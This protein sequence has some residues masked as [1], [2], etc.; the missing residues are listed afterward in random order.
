MMRCTIVIFGVHFTHEI[1]SFNCVSDVDMPVL[2][3]YLKFTR[4]FISLLGFIA[5]YVI[6]FKCKKWFE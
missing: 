1:V 4:S 2:F 3:Y 5:K 6:N